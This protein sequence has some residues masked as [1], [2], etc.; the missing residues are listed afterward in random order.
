MQVLEPNQDRSG[1]SADPQTFYI[2]APKIPRR[3][4]GTHHLRTDTSHL[5]LMVARVVLQRM[6]I[7]WRQITRSRFTPPLPGSAATDNPL[8]A[9][10]RCPLGVRNAFAKPH[11]G[12]TVKS[13]AL[14]SLPMARN[15]E[16]ID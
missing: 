4:D 5:G 7:Q 8:D 3:A 6:L 16:C 10:Q 9:R 12:V 2:V 14:L 1:Q 13:T 15:M 11:E